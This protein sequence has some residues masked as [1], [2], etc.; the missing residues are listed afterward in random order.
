MKKRK[1]IRNSALFVT[2]KNNN[3]LN[4]SGKT[5]E[6]YELTADIDGVARMDRLV[7]VDQKTGFEWEL[8]I[9][10][11]NMVIEPYE[12]VEKRDFRIEKIIK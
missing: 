8:S 1:I 3:V 11:G 6:P 2:N 12:L 9:Y 5:E 7:L 10:D 4:L